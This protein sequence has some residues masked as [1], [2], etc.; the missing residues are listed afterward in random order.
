LRMAR[1]PVSESFT[2][3][4]DQGKQQQQ[5]LSSFDPSAGGTFR[6]QDFSPTMLQ[7]QQQQQNHFASGHQ[8]QHHG[9]HQQK[10]SHS[11]QP[12]PFHRGG[13]G[14]PASEILPQGHHPFHNNNFQSPEAEAIDKW[15]EDLSHYEQTL[16]E[17]AVVSLDM[18]FKD[19]LSTIESWFRVLSE[20]ERTAALYSLLQHSS[21]VQIRFFITVLQQM[22][23]KDPVGALLSPTHQN[24]KD[25]VQNQLH[26]AML[27]AEMEA[28]QRLLS[29]LPIQPP[30]PLDR[31]AAQRR[32]YDRHSVTISGSEEYN[33]LF[34]RDGHRNSIDFLGRTTP[35]TNNNINNKF[36]GS[37]GSLNGNTNG[38]TSG[39]IGSGVMSESIT[40]RANQFK[41]ASPGSLN[42][43]RI[44][45]P[46]MFSNR[47]KS[48]H[49]GDTSSMFSANWNFASL[50]ANPLPNGSNAISG[51]SGSSSGG[52]SSPGNIGDRTSFGRPKSVGGAEWMLSGSS[53]NRPSSSQSNHGGGSDG[54]DKPWTPLIMSPTMGGFHNGSNGTGHSL[55]A[56]SFSGSSSSGL[57]VERPKSVTEADLA[58]LNISQWV[59]N[60]NAASGGN[61]GGGSQRSSGSL[62][63]IKANNRR[64]TLL[65]PSAIISNV[66]VT[67]LEGDEKLLSASAN[68]SSINIVSTMFSESTTATA[69]AQG[70]DGSG[71][72]SGA[73]GGDASATT[74]MAT[75]QGGSSVFALDGYTQQQQQ[76]VQLLH[77]LTLDPSADGSNRSS[78]S[79]QSQQQQ[80]QQQQPRSRAASPFSSPLPSPIKSGFHSRPVSGPTSP[81]LSAQQQ[82]HHNNNSNHHHHGGSINNNNN[83]NA[84][85]PGFNHMG[86][87]GPNTFVGGPDGLIPV[88]YNQKRHL[89]PPGNHHSR[90]LQ[91]QQQLSQHQHQQMMHNNNLYNNN[92]FHHMGS[93]SS[94]AA[95]DDDYLS[96]TSDISSL[97]MNGG[98]HHGRGG[99]VP[100]DKKQP[101]GVDFELLQDT[102]AWLR[103][104]RLHKYNNIFEGMNWRDIVNLSDGDLI[105]KGVAALGAR[106]KMLKVFEQVRK[107]MLLQGMII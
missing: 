101:E 30:A 88:D 93:S 2:M 45:A 79:A 58:K 100:K 56:G 95:L 59:Q 99:S 51:S 22:A 25:P 63:E 19:E 81:R 52:G 43:N 68:T 75:G 16:E 39:V 104:L 15:F 48:V 4:S 42:S 70:G 65:R 86:P 38:N 3:L 26:G 71:S 67:V 83:N 98:H 29:V 24:E 94:T 87:G 6:Q 8:Q 62:E 60:N 103:S 34:R 84:W 97:G 82:Q 35:T 21:Q 66:P 106:R 17:M 13:G 90:P 85:T 37:T 14:R 89:S 76:A 1:R 49:E 32:L 18:V 72:V 78:T 36:G 41:N 7:Q 20:A 23:K 69:A 61:G 92:H 28:S 107:E 10:Q 46:N 50:G 5:Q 96:D 55:S 33:R 80:Q 53:H 77:T 105:N 91:H 54:L 40:S 73:S 74:S 64:R 102:P 44:S 11:Q 27:K 9:Q 47:P 57:A 31:P 12:Q